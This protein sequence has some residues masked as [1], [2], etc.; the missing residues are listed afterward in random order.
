MIPTLNR[1]IQVSPLA[2][3][4]QA[5]RSLL[6][7]TASNAQQRKAT[8]TTNLAVPSTEDSTAD[9]TMQRSFFSGNFLAGATVLIHPDLL[10][11]ER[12]NQKGK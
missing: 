8:V 7:L 12:K 9:A 2:R 3:W 11:P 4:I 10:L 5:L 6:P 1:H